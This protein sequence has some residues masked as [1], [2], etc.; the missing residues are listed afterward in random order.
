MKKF[1]P[2]FFGLMLPLAGAIADDFTTEAIEF[3]KS[4]GGSYSM[5]SMVE[6]GDKY[7]RQVTCK[8]TNNAEG[9][10]EIPEGAPGPE[11]NVEATKRVCIAKSIVDGNF[12]TLLDLPVEQLL[13]LPQVQPVDQ[14]LAQ[15]VDQPLVPLVDQPLVPPV[16]QPLVQEVVQGTLIFAKSLKAKEEFSRVVFVIVSVNR[17]EVS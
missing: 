15:L 11:A 12:N 6:E 16:E 7:C 10:Y 13:V 14:P 3:C 1:I 8:K 9:K 17:A 4:K 5:G 2:L